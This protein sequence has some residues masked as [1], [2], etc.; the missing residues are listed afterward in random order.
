[1]KKFHIVI[2]II[3]GSSIKLKFNIAEYE[4]LTLL[5]LRKCITVNICPR[6]APGTL[7]ASRL[8]KSMSLDWFM[9]I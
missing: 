3:R 8:A 2:L 9:H 1:M 4:R 5:N 6:R 7:R